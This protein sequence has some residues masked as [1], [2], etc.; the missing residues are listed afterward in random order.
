MAG[1]A[2]DACG[3]ACKESATGCVE[4]YQVR[5]TRKVLERPHRRSCWH[6][7]GAAL[8]CVCNT[9]NSASVVRGGHDVRWSLRTYGTVQYHTT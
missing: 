8:S 7:I 1:V 2:E 4:S 3:Q 9:L 5:E 6:G